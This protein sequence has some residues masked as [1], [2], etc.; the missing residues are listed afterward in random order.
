MFVVGD[1]VPKW[2]PK[3][4]SQL[5][6]I[7]SDLRLRNGNFPFQNRNGCELGLYI[8][9]TTWTLLWDY[10]NFVIGWVVSQFQEDKE[11]ITLYCSQ[12]L[13]PSQMCY[14][15]HHQMF[16]VVS[17]CVQFTSFI[18]ESRL[19][20]RTDHN[21]LVCLS[22]FNNINNIKY[23]IYRAHI[24]HN[25]TNILAM[26]WLLSLGIRPA[27]SS[28]GTCRQPPTSRAREHNTRSIFYHPSSY[29]HLFYVHLF[30]SLF[31]Y[32]S[33][34]CCTRASQEDSHMAMRCPHY[35]FTIIIYINF[36]L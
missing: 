17:M 25:S 6:T 8:T 34:F 18:C 27:G 32:C 15:L 29:L 10:S 4:A 1:D 35:T 26:A 20:F 13:Q 3:W 9:T 21:S 33:L 14:V 28:W 7:M 24:I 2:L 16:G 23:K 12:A 11:N 30:I 5:K 36:K 19:T 22:Q 31:S